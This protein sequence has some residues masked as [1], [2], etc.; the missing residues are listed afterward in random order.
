MPGVTS[1]RYWAVLQFCNVLS[2]STDM[3]K[4]RREMCRNVHLSTRESKSEGFQM[5]FCIM[6]IHL[7]ISSDVKFY[8]YTPLVTFYFKVLCHSTVTGSLEMSSHIT[9][10]KLSDV[11]PCTELSKV[12]VQHFGEYSL[13]LFSFLEW[14]ENVRIKYRHRVWTWLRR[15]LKLTN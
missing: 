5:K 12:L 7:S 10:C 4:G 9:K 1:W 3:K 2:L 15:P 13:C 14:D 8:K 11:V 6:R